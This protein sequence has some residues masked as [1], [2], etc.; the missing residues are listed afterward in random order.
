MGLLNLAGLAYLLS[1]PVLIYIYYFSRK[2]KRVEISSI[3]P[4]KRLRE[5]VVRSSLFRAD[6]LFYL[7]LA[8]LSLL[9]LA[10]C[11]PYWRHASGGTA[12][13]HIVLVLDRSASMQAV[14]GRKSRFE[15]A[16]E[17]AL[18]LVRHL[19]SRDRV[20]LIAAGA[21]PEL[22]ASGEQ[23]HAKV[24]A[25]IEQLRPADTPDRM[26]PA[27]Q[28]ALGL[29]REG[30]KAKRRSPAG[31]AGS[32]E[33]PEVSLSIFTDRSAESLGLGKL[34]DW[35]S[36]HVEHVGAP[37]DNTALTSISVYKDLFSP[38]QEVSAYV[39]VDNFSEKSFSGTLSAAA[40]GKRIASREIALPPGGSLTTKIGEEVPEGLL[41]ISLDPPDALPVD[42]KGYAL[43]PGNRTT[44]VA[45]FTKDYRLAAQL[46]DLAKAIP[47]LE[48]DVKSPGSYRVTDMAPYTVS[49]FHACEPKLEPPTSLLFICPPLQSRIVRVTGDCASGVR[50][51]DWDEG[52][53]VGENLR[54]LQNVPLG[55]SRIIAT[56][57]WARPV[58]IS[59]TTGGDIPLVLCGEYRGRRVTVMSFDISTMELTKSDSLPVLLLLLNILKWLGE[60]EHNQIATG[61]AY[62]ALV[63]EAAHEKT[64]E[65]GTEGTGDT[66]TVINP[67]GQE[68][69]LSFREGEPL[70]IN[71][72]DYAGMYLVSGGFTQRAFVANLSSSAE[73]D[74]REDRPGE[75]RVVAEEV[76]SMSL[77]AS[78][79][80][81]WSSM[82]LWCAALLLLLEWIVFN[83]MR[84]QRVAEEPELGE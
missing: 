55:G 34:N 35:G 4:W 82:L 46:R 13:R 50:F 16:R 26:A 61:E 65:A 81:D 3:I 43:L 36:I 73:S 51:L 52:H 29:V 84:P 12:G 44:K 9:V 6:I 53:P 25:L 49:I 39:T 75:D 32:E 74:L 64:P 60:P 41:D 80:A 56:P 48:L 19:G 57:S 71:A 58:A 11:Q 62:S 17:R 59:A 27:L 22:L 70:T 66:F 47:H 2:R 33:S 8:L 63:P 21:R 54:G 77:P 37:K 38:R 83:F 30:E 5:S 67:I 42:N 76:V 1:I 78:P 14:E 31:G 28:S 20:T 68:E 7:Q 24:E 45:L 72:T 40:K 69:R 10:A 79:P 15:L 18:A 23:N